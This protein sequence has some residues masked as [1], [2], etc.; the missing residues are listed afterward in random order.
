MASRKTLIL[1]SA[2]WIVA[3]A[4]YLA[5]AARQKAHLN[6]SATAGGQYPYLVYAEGLAEPTDFVHDCKGYDDEEIRL[7][8]RENALG[9]IEP[10]RR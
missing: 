2:F 6:L 1:V 9:L 8:M 5:A 10:L 4:A 7:V 3:A